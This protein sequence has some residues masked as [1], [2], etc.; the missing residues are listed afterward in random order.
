[1]DQAVTALLKDLRQRGLLDT[2]VVALCTEFGRTPWSDG[3]NGKG[4]NHYAK[5]FTSLLA[6]AGVRGGVAYGETDEFG[7][8]IVKNPCHVH[9]YHATLLHLMGI[10]HEHLTYRYGGRDFRLT[11]I[12]GNVVREILA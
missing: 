8:E 7:A 9:D 5:A 12:A 11:D 4:R 2:T 10:D 1:M 3:G 6:G